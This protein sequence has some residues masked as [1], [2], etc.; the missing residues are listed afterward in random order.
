MYQKA[1]NR[2]GMKKG[3]AIHKKK[4]K[5]HAARANFVNFKVEEAREIIHGRRRVR[6]FPSSQTGKTDAAPISPGPFR[7]PST[8]LPEHGA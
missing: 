3:G 2:R 5:P 7:Y 4:Q 6:E 8:R 1:P